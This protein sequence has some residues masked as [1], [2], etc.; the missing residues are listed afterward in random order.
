LWIQEGFS[1]GPIHIQKA[2][3]PSHQDS[4][5][6]SVHCQKVFFPWWEMFY[7][8]KPRA[9]NGKL[10]KRTPEEITHFVTPLAL[11]IWYMD[12][13]CATYQAN[14]SCHNQDNVS[15]A[16]KILKAF[17]IETVVI[18]EGGIPKGID[19][20]G[21]ENT[22]AFINIV[23]AH[24][25][26]DLEY[27]L[28][29]GCLYGFK[30]RFEADSLDQ[31]ESEEVKALVEQGCTITDI[32]RHTGAPRHAVKRKLEILHLA[33]QLTHSVDADMK[34][35]VEHEK[36]EGIKHPTLRIP[37]KH[38]EDVML[39]GASVRYAAL[40]FGVCPKVL[41]RELKRHNL[42]IPESPKPKTADL[43]A[44]VTKELLWET[45]LRT[46]TFKAC[47]QALAISQQTVNRKLREYGLFNDW[48]KQPEATGSLVSHLNNQS[49]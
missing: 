45:L 28:H 19:T 2:K 34:C 32:V 20:E 11:A 4:L 5:S 27:K 13:G 38:L 44:H 1:V 22:R 14:L 23:K 16:Q 42:Q 10:Y 9:K 18:K 35:F 43:A 46:K 21:L 6:F 36:V 47:A 15:A 49:K 37:K 29:P 12:D 3:K 33:P 40:R 30:T 17:G 26:P 24:I 25:H 39:T 48:W 41:K 31:I 8:K 7:G